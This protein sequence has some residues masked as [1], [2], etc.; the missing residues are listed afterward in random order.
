MGVSPNV[1][2]FQFSYRFLSSYR[3]AR[4]QSTILFFILNIKFQEID[5]ERRVAQA[6]RAPQPQIT[7]Y[8]ISN[9]QIIGYHITKPQITG[10]HISNTQII[11]YHITKPQIT[12]YHIFNTK[13]SLYHFISNFYLVLHLECNLYFLFLIFISS[14]RKQIQREKVQVKYP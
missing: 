7:G 2:G 6:R 5:L 12:G 11:G 1:T 9:T 4:Q 3:I 14:F 8:H 10:Y 13:I